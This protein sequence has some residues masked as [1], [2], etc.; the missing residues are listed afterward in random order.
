VIVGFRKKSH[1]GQ[2][3][4]SMGGIPPTG[5]LQVCRSRCSVNAVR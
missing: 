4:A 1:I 3:F 5:C 2:Y